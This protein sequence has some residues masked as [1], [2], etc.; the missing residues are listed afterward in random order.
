MDV[1]VLVTINNGK[2]TIFD[3]DITTRNDGSINVRI[4]VPF[5]TNCMK[6]SVCSYNIVDLNM[7]EY[8]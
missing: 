6:I 7:L 1:N 3:D 4:P 5:D 8:P 2:I